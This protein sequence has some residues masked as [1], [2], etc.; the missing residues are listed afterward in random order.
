[1]ID[2]FLVNVAIFEMA[3]NAS[4]HLKNHC[5]EGYLKEKSW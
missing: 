5:E 3:K 1:M 4:L 2:D